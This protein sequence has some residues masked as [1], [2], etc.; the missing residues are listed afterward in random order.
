VLATLRRRRAVLVWRLRRHPLLWWAVAGAAAALTFL[1]VQDLASAPR[2]RC[3]MADEATASG[4]AGE[5]GGVLARQLPADARAVAVPVSGSLSVEVGDRVDLIAPSAPTVEGLDGTTQS[6]A[7]ARTVVSAALVAEVADEAVTL[8][9]DA[10]D[11]PEVAMAAAQGGATLALV[12]A[13]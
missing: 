5:P 8:A 2:E 9:V 10:A 1:V 6:D 4:H 7:A 12:A 3:P 13:G 11:A